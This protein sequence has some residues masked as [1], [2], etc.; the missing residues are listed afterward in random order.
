MQ[1]SPY[2]QFAGNC[3]E[4][5]TAYAKILGGEI[6]FMMTHE[7]AP[8]ETPDGWR[9]KIMHASLKFGDNHVMGSDCPPAYYTKP[10][11]FNVSIGL[12]D[13]AKAA[14]IFSALAEGGAISMPL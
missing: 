12:K 2:L 1:I 3:R 13:P 4:A 10:G 11:G 6:T 5:F 9:D 7:E 14:E 8:M